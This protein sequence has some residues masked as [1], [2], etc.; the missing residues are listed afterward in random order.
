M[1]L[2][3]MSFSSNEKHI[4]SYNEE[5]QIRQID[6]KGTDNDDDDDRHLND[7]LKPSDLIIS[8]LNK[9]STKTK[10]S[11]LQ[12]KSKSTSSI[13]FKHNKSSNNID[14]NR[15]TKAIVKSITTY[16]IDPYLFQKQQQRYSSSFL[17]KNRDDNREENES[18]LKV[19]ETAPVPNLITTPKPEMSTK[20][21]E[22]LMQINT[23]ANDNRES[24]SVAN[25]DQAIKIMKYSHL[26]GDMA[27]MKRND[28]AIDDHNDDKESIKFI[29]NP[30]VVAFTDQNIQNVNN[31]QFVDPSSSK[32]LVDVDDL[33]HKFMNKNS[34]GEEMPPHNSLLD[35]NKSLATTHTTTNINKNND[36]SSKKS[37][38]DDVM[39]NNGR[40]NNHNNNNNN[41]ED[42]R[43]KENYHDN[44]KL[45]VIEKSPYELTPHNNF[46]SMNL[47]LS[48]KVPVTSDSSKKRPFSKNAQNINNNS[49][50][51]P[52][53]LKVSN[54][55]SNASKVTTHNIQMSPIR[56]KSSERG[57]VT[58]SV[59]KTAVDLEA[60]REAGREYMKKQ[61]EQRKA[62]EIAKKN[63]NEKEIIKQRLEALRKRT[64]NLVE[65]NVQKKKTSKKASPERNQVK[66]TQSREIEDSNLTRPK[67]DDFKSRTGSIT[68]KKSP[69]AIKKD[70]SPK[71]IIQK[72][73]FVKSPMKPVDKT[74]I[75]S[76]NDHIL[77]E[78]VLKGTVKG[79]YEPKDLLK[80]SQ[81]LGLLRKGNAF[82][83]DDIYS[84]LKI[85]DATIE[86]QTPRESH[87][88]T[89]INRSY[90][91]LT[92]DP[93][94]TSFLI[95]ENTIDASINDSKNLEKAKKNPIKST[96]FNETSNKSDKM[97]V[98]DEPKIPEWLQPT[99]AQMFSFNFITAL[100]K[101]MAAALEETQKITEQAPKIQ[102][103]HNKYQKMAFINNKRDYDSC[104]FTEI[105][106]DYDPNQK[107]KGQF[108]QVI[109]KIEERPNFIVKERGSAH[110]R[111]KENIKIRNGHEMLQQFPN[112]SPISSNHESSKEITDTDPNTISEIT[113]IKSDNQSI[114]L[115]YDE[116]KCKQTK[117]D[118]DDMKRQV[119]GDHQPLSMITKHKINP[120]L[121]PNTIYDTTGNENN[122]NQF[123]LIK[124][125]A[126]QHHANHQ[127]NVNVNDA[128]QQPQNFVDLNR[129]NVNQ[130][131]L[132][133]K[134]SSKT[135][136]NEISVL[137]G[138]Q[139]T[140]G[141]VERNVRAAMKKIDSENDKNGQNMDET[142][143][144]LLKEFKQSLNNFI[145]LN[146]KLKS[147]VKQKQEQNETQQVVVAQSSKNLHAKPSDT[148]ND[149][150]LKDKNKNHS[151]NFSQL[152]QTPKSPIKTA[153]H[154]TRT[155][156][157]EYSS[158]FESPPINSDMN[159]KEDI[160]SSLEMNEENSSKKII[161][162][163]IVERMSSS[164]S[165]SSTATA[166]TNET[167]YDDR[168]VNKKSD[169]KRDYYEPQ[170][171]EQELIKSQNS[172][173]IEESEE[174]SVEE[175]ISIGSYSNLS[176]E[177]S[178]KDI[179]IIR[180]NS[181]ENKNHTI[182]TIKNEEKSV[183]SQDTESLRAK[184][185][186]NLIQVNEGQST[187]AGDTESGT[188]STESQKISDTVSN[189]HESALQKQDDQQTD[190]EIESLPNDSNPKDGKYESEFETEATESAVESSIL[191]MSFNESN[192]NFSYSTVGMVDQMIYSEEMKSEQ[193]SAIIGLRTKS[194]IDRLKGQISF[195]EIKKQRCKGQPVEAQSIKKR[196]RAILM[197]LEQAKESLKK[198]VESDGRNILQPIPPPNIN[199]SKNNS[200][201][202]Y[203][204]LFEKILK[205][206]INRNVP[207]NAIEN[208]PS[209]TPIK[210]F[211]IEPSLVLERLLEKRQREL[212]VRKNKLQKLSEWQAQL[213]EEERRVI[214]M[215]QQLL[216]QNIAEAR[217]EF[218][219]KSIQS[220]ASSDISE[221]FSRS[222]KRLKSRAIEDKNDENKENLVQISSKLHKI[223]NSLSILSQEVSDEN[224]IVVLTGQ[225]L[226]KLWFRLSGQK[227]KRFEPN[228]VYSL[229]KKKVAELYEEAKTVVINQ[230]E[231]KNKVKQLLEISKL[232]ETVSENLQ[233]E[234]KRESENKEGSSTTALSSVLDQ[235]EKENEENI[236]VE[237]VISISGELP[238]PAPNEMEPEMT[239]TEENIKKLESLDLEIS[240][241][242]NKPSTSPISI[243]EEM[244]PELSSTK[245]DPI[246]DPEPSHENEFSYSDTFNNTE[247]SPEHEETLLD[248]VS[249][250]KI[251]M[252]TTHNETFIE[253][254][255][256]KSDDKLIEEEIEKETETD[257]IET[258]IH[259]IDHHGT[260]S[261]SSNNIPC[262]EKKSNDPAQD[263]SEEPL[264]SPSHSNSSS[265]SNSNSKVEQRS[266]SGSD[267]SDEILMAAISTI[268]VT[269]KVVSAG[270]NASLE[271]KLPDIINEAEVLRR[272]QM[273]IEQEIEELQQ[274][275]PFYLRDIPNKPPPP[276]TLPLQE[277]NK[278]RFPSIQTIQN[279][280]MKRV[281]KL[282]RINKKYAP[283]LNGIDSNG[284]NSPE[285]SLNIY[286]RLVIDV[287][288]ELFYSFEKSSLS[289]KQT[290][291]IKNSL[292]FYN[293]PNELE[294][295]QNFISKKVKKLS[296]PLARAENSISN[297][298]DSLVGGNSLNNYQGILGRRNP[299][300][301][302]VDEVL[303]L[304]LIEDDPNWSY[305]E[306]EEIVVKNDLVNGI[307][308]MLVEEAVTEFLQII[309]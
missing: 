23:V 201:S 244:N 42:D 67:F 49:V 153:S 173:S 190:T 89:F 235:D 203:L 4:K 56:A 206:R 30:P 298:F 248:N 185:N 261:S 194:M 245:N 129:F 196:Q 301:D 270:V 13:N 40:N 302:L 287:S 66:R 266:G 180:E 210:G 174:K 82:I 205:S 216:E 169:R 223:E 148:R 186:A 303:M 282:Y 139:E 146:Q 239:L 124:N 93:N 58:A 108:H 5:K 218:K 247:I 85:H 231:D 22:N 128:Q 79:I 26:S 179:P 95:H 191:E 2:L 222:E 120:K 160:I 238:V 51:C 112:I 140:S 225:K 215:E 256:E 90:G 243:E 81:A 62:E 94:A 71:N 275:V 74:P 187:S 308:K 123:I 189:T 229:D 21:S 145:E 163:N 73:K 149:D 166:T 106:S 291:V 53:L 60:S 254:S 214:E 309:T 116:K 59:N 31:Y 168:D 97:Q 134:S 155:N 142:Y 126:D 258:S 292:V 16:K 19:N 198:I 297:D 83:Q 46:K 237:P 8:P 234:E 35:T 278:D 72:Q 38:F 167:G 161:T 286:E 115:N 164:S 158:N 255:L 181:Q 144:A 300:K 260:S 3:L 253:K 143:A 178:S 299:K 7:D 130:N 265:S 133:Q 39:H 219:M 204:H 84:P 202:K 276:Y 226:N 281:E 172:P 137:S 279:L 88:K 207:S 192:L 188:H 273:Q 151:V 307:L 283:I 14:N 290:G 69:V 249:F 52:K 241:S 227:E 33:E 103:I 100:K 111:N 252:T 78:K 213:D 262:N 267:K 86:N 6:A 230:F 304:E 12:L 113:S 280:A 236:S 271:Y 20:E 208:K 11:K 87:G 18:M 63:N 29:N 121:D 15:S 157:T 132:K 288:E 109:N 64:R 175:N 54:S 68:S 127:N 147:A 295:L 80:S 159:N 232:Q 224:E 171:F 170:K 212:E 182:T 61:Q 77:H 217:K 293:P 289:E 156:Q 264:P 242:I 107:N 220:T 76:K 43:E 152:S 55:G 274:Q 96:I 131:I 104:S 199:N 211:E 251:D 150:D 10:I 259:E 34:T 119:E 257:S 36:N 228:R 138:N 176:N 65:H 27:M 48:P 75:R 47:N 184:L 24:S 101:K 117:V 240:E 233:E 57:S 122:S 118:E 105:A 110:K 44:I 92:L 263:I 99:S 221:S 272:Q 193:M 285:V 162:K 70:I 32:N 102:E 28:E 250:P 136:D 284:D 195:L 209:K 305:F 91:D 183:S 50:V 141:D 268:K 125:T 200:R 135:I 41:R 269:P 306:P 98:D 165:I 45:N 296:E 9:S 114:P 277:S 17:I 37:Y 246:E 1:Q 154:E 294:C 25:H 197:K 177:I